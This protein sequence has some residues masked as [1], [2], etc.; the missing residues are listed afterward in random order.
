MKTKEPLKIIYSYA[1]P[2][3]SPYDVDIILFYESTFILLLLDRQ[4]SALRILDFSDTQNIKNSEWVWPPELGIL[5]HFTLSGDGLYLFVRSF[6]QKRYY[7]I[8]VKTLTIVAYWPMDKGEGLDIISVV[9]SQSGDEVVI[10]YKDHQIKKITTNLG[11]QIVSIPALSPLLGPEQKCTICLRELLL[12]RH[13]I[14]Q[15]TCCGSLYCHHCLST[16]IEGGQGC[17]HCRAT[18]NAI[19]P[20]SEGVPLH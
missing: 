9:L 11:H 7:Y 5:D 15:V 17:P 4:R 12:H 6:V 2:H 20:E 8:S 19:P 3:Y 14:V 16:V 10:A 18:L 13:D 1:L